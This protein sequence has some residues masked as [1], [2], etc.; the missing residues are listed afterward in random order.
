MA[1]FELSTEVE[2]EAQRIAAQLVAR[3]APRDATAAGP[4]DVQRVDVDSL[5]LAR[6]RSVGVEQVGLWAL[7]QL[8]L[9]ALLAELG[10]NG[11]L[12]AAAAGALVGRLAQ[13]ASE[14]ATHRWLPARSGLGELLG[15]DFETVS[16]MQLYRASDALVKHREA[17][18][19]HLLSASV[20][21]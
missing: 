3:G 17:I 16:A 1:G 11:A 2:D 21:K 10:V 13:P 18:E 15:V 19:A 5:R 7:E 4:A 12:R 6:P 20:K 8:E 9:P 14:R